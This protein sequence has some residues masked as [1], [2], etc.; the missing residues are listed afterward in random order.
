[1]VLVTHKHKKPISPHTL[2]PPRFQDPL[3]EE[4]RAFSRVLERKCLKMDCDFL[5]YD[6]ER[7]IWMFQVRHFS[8][9]GFVSFDN[10]F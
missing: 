6:A 3:S 9:Y 10:S 4:A 5:E 8:R 2:Y 7:G 1:M